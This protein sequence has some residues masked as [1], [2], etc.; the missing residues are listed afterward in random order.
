VVDTIHEG[1]HAQSLAEPGQAL[2]PAGLHAGQFPASPRSAQANC[3]AGDVE[4]T[5]DVQYGR[6]GVEAPSGLAP[7]GW[8]QI[9]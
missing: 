7:V 6:C 1:I 5:G 3:V 8:S 2:V 9:G 4:P